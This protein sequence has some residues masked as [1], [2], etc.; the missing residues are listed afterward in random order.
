MEDLVEDLT[1][2]LENSQEYECP[3]SPCSESTLP[4]D[5]PMS[6]PVKRVRKKRARKRRMDQPPLWECS[7][8]SDDSDDSVDLALKDYLE[9]ITTN[10][11]DSETDEA[12]MVKKLSSLK[13]HLC[14]DVNPEH[15]DSDSAVNEVATTRR[16]RKRKRKVK[17]A[18]SLP[19]SVQSNGTTAQAVSCTPSTLSRIRRNR[20]NIRNSRKLR[21]EYYLKRDN[22]RREKGGED[23]SFSGHDILPSRELSSDVKLTSYLND[24]MEVS[25]Y[26]DKEKDRLSDDSDDMMAVSTSNSSKSSTSLTSSEENLFTNDEGGLGDDEKEESCFESD[27]NPWWEEEKCQS[28]MEED[29]FQDILDGKFKFLAPSMYTGDRRGKQLSEFI[30]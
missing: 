5:S 27:F 9:N 13:V 6:A 30:H 2:A 16:K 23:I 18:L 4:K 7:K 21:K 24:D 29:K 11:S 20:G 26:V 12:E 1:Y 28:D 8:F 15:A 10:Q 17:R 14:P 3:D 25:C 19:L 22:I